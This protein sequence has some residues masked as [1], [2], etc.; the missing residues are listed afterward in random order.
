MKAESKPFSVGGLLVVVITVAVIVVLF[1]LG[2]QDASPGGL[3]RPHNSQAKLVEKGSCILC[4]GDG[5]LSMD[6][7][8]GE[9]HGLVLQS[10]DQDQGFH[11]RL[12]AETQKDC[13]LCHLDHNGAS[14]A[15]VSLMSYRLAGIEDRDEYDHGGPSFALSAHDSALDCALCHPNADEEHLTEGQQRFMGLESTCSACHEDVHIGELGSDCAKCHGQSQP[16]PQVAAF[17]HESFEALGAHRGLGCTECHR[18][19]GEFDLAGWFDSDELYDQRSCA[20][21]HDS[22]HSIDFIDMVAQVTGVSSEASCSQCHGA[23][24]RSFAGDWEAMQPELHLASGVELV[25]AHSE[26]ACAECHAGD[27]FENRFPGRTAQSCGSC[28]ADPHQVE[29]NSTSQSRGASFCADCHTQDA[30]RPSTFD[31]QAHLG[32]SFELTGSHRA[33]ACGECHA[34]QVPPSPPEFIGTATQ[35]AACHGDPHM[36]RLSDQDCAR[37]HGT[38]LF[39]EVRKDAFDHAA[40]TQFLLRG[41]HL[42]VECDLCHT[43]SA[44]PDA[45]G[46]SFGFVESLFG[47][48]AGKCANCHQDVHGGSFEHADLPSEV[49]GESGCARCHD[50]TSFSELLSVEFNHKRWTG[51]ALDG[52]HTELGCEAC[53]FPRE[54]ADVNGRRF[55]LVQE[56]FPSKAQGCARCHEDPHRG[57]FDREGLPVIFGGRGGCARCHV[58]ESFA[59]ESR[60]DFDHDFWTGFKLLGEHAGL[61]CKACH[62]ELSAPGS[63]VRSFAPAQG[64]ACIDC[65]SAPHAGQFA[66]QGSTDCASCHLPQGGLDFVHDLDT[67][68]P[69]DETHQE[70][71]CSACHVPWPLADGR[72]VVRYKPL[73]T[74]CADCHG[75]GFRGQGR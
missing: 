37:C 5:T 70:L 24:K 25:G 59:L 7:A 20:D 34:E 74:L 58:E 26:L 29:F 31:V 6:Q 45:L 32:A 40:D 49:H 50:E 28:H 72:S 30:F 19:D 1:S 43:P 23:E 52:A 61:D 2:L 60:A 73:G 10:I 27:S 46:R 4:H 66:I 16:F 13:R 64:S 44:L 51:H 55:G 3:S 12:S 22:P 48:P 36:E 57:E 41:A 47:S 65:H 15:L 8:C 35:C 67:R 62:A 17:E 9:C 11:G 71:K 69:L 38:T 18:V 39:A 56:S 68:F 33:V 42:E 75:E 14:F 63:G 21:C 54:V 53:H